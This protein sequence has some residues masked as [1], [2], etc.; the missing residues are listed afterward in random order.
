MP[1][2]D[3]RQCEHAIRHRAK[4]VVGA[5]RWRVLA[6]FR[7]PRV[8]PADRRGV[9]VDLRRGHVG[10]R[11]GAAGHRARAT[12]RRRCRWL[13]HAWA[14]VSSRSCSSAGS[15]PTGSTSGRSSSP[16]RLVN[17]VGR[18]GGR[19]AGTRWRTADLAYGRRRG[20]VGYRRGV[21]L[22]GLQRDAAAD[23]AC[24]A[25]AGRQR[26]RRCGAPG[27]PARRRPRRRR[28]SGG[29]DVSCPGLDRG[30]GVVRDRP[31]IAGGHPARSENA[32]PGTGS[33][34]A[35]HAARPAGRLRLRAAHPVAVVDP[36]VREH[37]RARGARPDRGAAAVHRQGPV[38]P[39]APEPTGS[40]WRSS[41]WAAPW[42]RSRCRRAGC[43]AAI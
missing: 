36:A 42:A 9:A 32:C 10:R 26:R 37:V 38:R 22:P 43:P 17:T 5:G 35:A 25:A 14:L 23:P 20:G 33:T 40:S 18:V 28:R 4:P 7:S 11:D 30:G 24:R 31:D 12:I 15:R 1:V 3:H 34:T 16:S 8:P 6:P 39:T 21:L 13:P 27:L 29:C 41:A 2:S 19:R